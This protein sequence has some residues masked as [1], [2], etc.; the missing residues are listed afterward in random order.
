M[1]H[2]P[3]LLQKNGKIMVYHVFINYCFPLL[4]PHPPNLLCNLPGRKGSVGTQSSLVSKAAF[5]PNCLKIRL[6]SLNCT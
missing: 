5:S 1:N 4:P 6:V 2:L 3:S